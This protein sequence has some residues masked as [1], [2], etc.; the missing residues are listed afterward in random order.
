M[1]EN[2]IIARYSGSD[3]TC[4]PGSNQEDDG[5][6]NLEYNM[7]RLVTRVSSKNFCIVKPS[8]E[9]S[10]IN[11]QSS[12]KV[13]LQ[14]SIGQCSIN[15][16]DLIMTNTLKIDP[17]AKN[18]TYHL[19]FKL[20]RDSSN[21]VL[22][23]L[24]VGV[25]TTFEGVYL[26]Y[27]SKKP[28]PQTDMD[29]LY[30][31]QVTWDGNDF[32]NIIEDEDKYGR[33]WA[34]DV[35][36]KFLDPKHPDTTRLNLQQFI[37]TLPDWYFSKEGDTVYGPIIIK[38]NRTDN[39][40]GI[41]INADSNSSHIVIKDPQADNDKLQ[42]YGD[43]NRDGI[44]DQK[45]LDL[46]NQFINKTK[47]PNA[48]Q[49]ILADVNHDG[50]IDQK[51]VIYISNF[52]KKKGNPADTGNI[53]FIDNTTHGLS[54]NSNKNKSDIN[55][56]SASININKSDNYKLHITNP[57]DIIIKSESDTIIQGNE[58]VQIGTNN[59]RP[60][61]TLGNDKASFTDTAVSPDLKFDINFVDGNNIQQTLGKA[62]W[63][64]NNTTQNISL[65]QNN[66]KYLDIVPNGI[67]RQN[68]RV[69]TSL[70]LGS[71]DSLPQTTLSRTEWWLR[72][73]VQSNGNT[74]N[75]TPDRIIMTNPTLTDKDN[76]YILLRNTQDTIHTKIFDDAKIEL[77][78]P[79]RASSI[80]W[81]DG[82]VAFDIILSKVINQK[83]LNL[84]G[85]FNLV[86]LTA[87]GSVTGNGLIT[88][89][90]ILTFK[91]GTNDATITKDNNGSSLRT[92]GPLYIGA[93]GTQPLYSGNTVV[94]GTFGV[95]G[96]TYANSELKVD[97]S[98]NLNTSGT[99]T[100]SKVYNSVY[101]GFGEIFR[102]NKNEIIEY[103]DVVC[104]KEDG[105]AHKVNNVQDLDTIIG[106]CSNTIGVQMGGKD[107]PKEEQLE[108]EMLGQIWVKTKENNIKPGQLVKVNTDATVSVTTNK[109]EKFGITLTN[110]INGKVQIVYNG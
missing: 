16:M 54:F 31:G 65:L 97:S 82:N 20:A 44:I 8:F 4:Y 38:D 39:N 45:D 90:G 29:M 28:E 43:V 102:K 95:G 70:Y 72:Q 30:L 49:T 15:G 89:N 47:V 21:N 42:L 85:D 50:V 33:I 69:I 41:I 36:G 11:D 25:T 13:K 48:L 32:T 5:K 91:R 52:I 62:I 9:I 106:I 12:N 18:G 94:N 55:L 80:V 40:P 74:I 51:D 96:S 64:Y 24:K 2:Q 6:L 57:E 77:L 35:L 75:F 87:S 67:Y 17:P 56:G 66:V 107:I 93:S 26:T 34:E 86:N 109:N 19:A 88:S 78:N 3:I 68:L 101:N 60:K 63:Q 22:G 105:L 14:I 71:N 27:Y 79:T 83:K 92:N 58:T 61:L 99:I 110:V 53:Y 73:N 84:D 23:D 1:E 10:K 98:G 103:G 81:K 59:N 7:A 108:V 104:I 76:S 46:I 100:G 37:Y